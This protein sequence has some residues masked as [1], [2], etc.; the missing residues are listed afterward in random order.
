LKI[1]TVLEDLISVFY[2]RVCAACENILDKDEE[3][4]CL[5]CCYSLP[6]TNFHLHKGNQLE[7]L[8]WGK[9]NIESAAAYLYY[10]KT[11]KAQKIIHNLKY[12]GHKQVGLFLGKEYGKILK[13]IDDF[14]YVDI[15]IPVPLHQKKERQRGYNQS[16]Y[17]AKGLSEA[18]NKPV[19]FKS[20]MRIIDTKSQTKLKGYEKYLNVKGAF[21]TI[22]ADTLQDKHVLLVDD[23]ITKGSTIEESANALSGIQGIKISVAAI[24]FFGN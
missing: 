18:M 22:N 10:S 5:E 19:D 21:K 15:I 13:D 16:E 9:I 11:G 17:F 24:A 1:K 20:L 8:F 7:Q 12:H 6:E 2:P 4:L 23:V 3:V 14:K